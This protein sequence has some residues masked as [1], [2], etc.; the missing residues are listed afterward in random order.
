MVRKFMKDKGYRY[1]S[2]FAYAR[3]VHLTDESR[4]KELMII[5]I[6]DLGEAYGMTAAELMEGGAEA[7]QRA[8]VEQAHIDRIRNTLEVVTR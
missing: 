3:L 1:P 5:F 8:A 6:D 2:D 7:S 4:R